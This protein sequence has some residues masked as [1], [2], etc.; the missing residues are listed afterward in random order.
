[1]AQIPDLFISYSSHDRPWAD[2]LYAELKAS[3][4]TLDIFLDHESIPAN[5][6]WRQVL[7]AT[8]VVTKNLVVLW[9]EKAKESNEVGPEIQA[10]E[11]SKLNTPLADGLPRTLFYIPLQ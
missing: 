5:A 1:M 7:I 9:S 3:Y 2:R 8:A 6:N 10:F 11:Q 4:P